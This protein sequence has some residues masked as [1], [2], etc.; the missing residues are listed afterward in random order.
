MKLFLL[1][2]CN[3]VS[4][5]VVSDTI[6]GNNNPEVVYGLNE[7][8]EE[9]AISIALNVVFIFCIFFLAITIKNKNKKIKE[10]QEKKEF[11]DE[12]DA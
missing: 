9:T 3:I 2:L 6:T 4:N 8:A 10:L 5:G 11:K 1:N 7:L 12:E